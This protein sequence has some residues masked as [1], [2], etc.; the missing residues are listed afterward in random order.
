[1]N[2]NLFRMAGTVFCIE[3]LYILYTYFQV[4][5]ML[6]VGAG[7]ISM[8]VG[9]NIYVLI[10]LA[11]FLVSTVGVLIIKRWSLVTLWITL[12]VTFVFSIVL[13]HSW[14]ALFIYGNV[15]VWF[16][17]LIIAIFLSLEWKKDKVL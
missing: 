9:G 12:V 16:I 6:F 7:S 4:Y 17:D 11:L 8:M 14:P 10:C 2:K 5:K 3:A 1:M 15:Q 13:G